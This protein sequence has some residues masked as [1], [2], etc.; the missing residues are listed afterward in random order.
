MD[1]LAIVNKRNL[2][3]EDYY[4]DLELVE[5]KDFLG[6]TIEIEKETYEAY[7]NLKKYLENL[8]IFF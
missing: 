3:N 7:I 5:T 2:I 4:K 1:Y 8:N 6:N